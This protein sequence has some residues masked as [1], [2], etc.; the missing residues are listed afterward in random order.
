MSGACD[1]RVESRQRVCRQRWVHSVRG[2]PRRASE[3]VLAGRVPFS[4]IS[5]VRGPAIS[6]R[7]EGRVLKVEL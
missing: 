1:M 6:A 4:A 3:D 2:W 7:R 5:R